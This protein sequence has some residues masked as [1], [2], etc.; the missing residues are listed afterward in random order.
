MLKKNKRGLALIDDVGKFDKTE[1]V[2]SFS[3]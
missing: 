3:A 2:S 1:A